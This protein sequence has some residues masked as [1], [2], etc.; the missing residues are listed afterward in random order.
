[1]RRFIDTRNRGGQDDQGAARV[2]DVACGNLR[3]ERYLLEEYPQISWEFTAV[4]GCAELV[5]AGVGDRGMDEATNIAIEDIADA[6]LRGQAPAAASPLHFDLSVCFGFMHHLPTKGLREELLRSLVGA[7]A[8]R[9][10]IALSLW[11]FAEEPG[12][13]RKARI[14]TAEACNSLAVNL[15]PGD[16][17]LGWD[18]EEGSW[19]YCHSF[20]EEEISEIGDFDREH[21]RLVDRFL[22]D[23]RGGELNAYLV[24]ERL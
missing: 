15:D 20:S 23:G 16:Y 4:D 5:A 8:S 12:L 14:S 21:I 10:L 19:R 17:L 11:R 3:F 1:M 6:L 7:T 13:E 18:G 9:G 22:S 24:F 2:L